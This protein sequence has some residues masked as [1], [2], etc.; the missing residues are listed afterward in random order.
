MAPNLKEEKPL[1]LLFGYDS[2]PFTNKVRLAL[3]VKGIPFSY[4][5]VPSML[6]R[7]LLT[8]TF[9]VTYRKIPILAIGREIY[10]DTSL[11]IE[12]LEHYFP[13]E[14][15]Y[16]S[17]YPKFEGG[18][19]DEWSYKGL[20]RG[21]AS[22][23][24][25]RPF[26]R[27]TTGL[28]PSSVWS[29]PFGTDRSQLIGHTLDA[30]KLE[31]KIPQ[32]LATFDL[33][34]SLLEPTFTCHSTSKASADG[35]AKSPWLIPTPTPSLADI[36]LYY[37]LRWGIDI[38]SGKGIYNLTGGATSNT[39]HDITSSVF[40]AHR[41]PGIWTWF[42]AFEAYTS[43]L[44]DL[45][46]V[47]QEGDVSWKEKL[48]GTP[49]VEEGRMLVPAAVGWHEELDKRRGVGRGVRVAIAPDD[50]GRDNPTVG[51]VVGLGV[52]EVVIVPEGKG[53]ID[54]RVHFPRLGFVVRVVEGGAKL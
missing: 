52:E 28:I 33:H 17:V 46:T 18:A 13:V 21:F 34:L 23:W 4:I 1:V 50:T 32:N 8:S 3:R 51:T 42:H 22:F 48:K 54:V 49:L 5:P 7:P 27:A 29:S 14:E 19:L 20:V 25:D 53:E 2:S 26:F 11:I 30:S 31:S 10:C 43:S 6:P 36:S 15:G 45:E 44:P 12:A 41:Y 38:A 16:G 40:N 35:K 47:V 9:G 39:A 37:Q 24:T